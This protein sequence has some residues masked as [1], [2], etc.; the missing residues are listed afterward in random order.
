MQSLDRRQNG[1]LEG[2]RASFN[3]KKKEIVKT[4]IRENL[5]D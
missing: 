4:I 1:V 5:E 3:K 2:N